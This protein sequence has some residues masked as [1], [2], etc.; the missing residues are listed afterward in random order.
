M[1]GLGKGG[2][3]SLVRVASSGFRKN[4]GLNRSRVILPEHIPFRKLLYAIQ[5][6]I[7]DIAFADSPGTIR[8]C[9]VGL[10]SSVLG[11]LHLLTL[12]ST[13]IL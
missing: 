2:A 4:V 3:L 9:D 6:N 5:C 13:A 1:Q 8:R 10:F 11:S 7:S 12:R